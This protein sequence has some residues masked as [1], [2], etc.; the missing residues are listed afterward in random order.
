MKMDLDALLIWSDEHVLIINKPAGLLSIADGYDQEA[1][2]LKA[3]LEPVYGSLW[4]V[5][6]LDREASGVMVLARTAE[7]HRN[8]NE[9]F[10]KRQVSKVYHVLVSGS[11][12]WDETAIR[13]PLHINGDRQHRTLVDRLRGKPSETRIK[14]LQRF[15]G[16]TLV[17][18]APQTGRTH[19]IRAHLAAKGF[20]I[21]AD[22]L[23]GSGT[24]VYLSQIKQDYRGEKTTERPM[25]SRLGLHAWSFS[26]EHPHTGLRLS[27]NAEY[28]KDISLT[29]KQLRKYSLLT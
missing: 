17:E 25:L 4:I 6:R 8:L 13:L 12:S 24:G 26:F 15:R 11:P 19:Q 10:T 21:V 20:P 3:I 7:S 27:F 2:H 29:L 23:Y 1:A 9:Q 5:H 22:P 16:Y 14:V 18:A 28:P